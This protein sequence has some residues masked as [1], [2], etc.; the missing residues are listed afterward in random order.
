MRLLEKQLATVLSSST[1]YLNK[2]IDILKPLEVIAMDEK[3]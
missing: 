1:D 3:I 2:I